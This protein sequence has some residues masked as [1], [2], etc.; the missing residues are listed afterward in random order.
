MAVASP[1]V[2]T[3]AES[4]GFLTVLPVVT[5]TPEKESKS[6]TEDLE[7]LDIEVDEINDDTKRK[8]SAKFS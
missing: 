4:I 8:A 3:V 5:A 1:A 7:L 6:S 2:P